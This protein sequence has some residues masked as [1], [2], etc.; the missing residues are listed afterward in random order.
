MRQ[1][2]F[3]I[4]TPSPVVHSFIKAKATNDNCFSFSSERCTCSVTQDVKRSVAKTVN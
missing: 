1:L 2:S 3:S 4:S